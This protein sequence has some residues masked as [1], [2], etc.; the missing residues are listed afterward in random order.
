MLASL[1][2]DH[3]LVLLP[4]GAKCEIN[5]I[6]AATNDY[7]LIY[8]WSEDGPDR[9]IAAQKKAEPE[10]YQSVYPNDGD[11]GF[12]QPKLVSLADVWEVLQACPAW[13]SH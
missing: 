3:Q 11:R 2:Q 7:N 1:D 10:G 4:F 9:L 8:K 5:G 6:R 12:K 13:K